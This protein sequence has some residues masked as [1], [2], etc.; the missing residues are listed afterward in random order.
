[1]GIKDIDMLHFEAMALF[2]QYSDSYSDMSKFP[3]STILLTMQIP[4]LGANF[5]TVKYVSELHSVEGH[6]KKI[7]SSTDEDLVAPLWSRV[8]DGA[9]V[10]RNEEQYHICS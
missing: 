4:E 6:F 3:Q 8:I 10:L 7:F 2:M 9:V 1:M 5:G